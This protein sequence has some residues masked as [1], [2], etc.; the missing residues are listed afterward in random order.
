MATNDKHDILSI[1]NE[2]LTDSTPIEWKVVTVPDSPLA[3][4]MFYIHCVANLISLEDNEDNLDKFRNYNHYYKLNDEEINELIVL[5]LLLYPGNLAGKCI[6]HND[7]RC[8][9]HENRF[10]SI[11]EVRKTTPVP[12]EIQIGGQSKQV[13]RVMFAR[14]TFLEKMYFVPMHVYQQRL[15]RIKKSTDRKTGTGL[16]CKI[17]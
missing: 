11:K 13:Y 2:S 10:E 6:F 4:L 8:E 15:D 5:C 12:D 9:N 17:M 3:R 14:L 16:C 1:N 7:E